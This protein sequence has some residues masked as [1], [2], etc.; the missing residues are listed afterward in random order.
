MRLKSWV[1]ASIY[2]GALALLAV[3][4]SHLAITDIYHAEGDVALEWLV[5]RGCFGVIVV[6][7]IIALVTLAKVLRQS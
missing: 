5:L 2:L 4:A 7:Q 3:L 1:K 6:A